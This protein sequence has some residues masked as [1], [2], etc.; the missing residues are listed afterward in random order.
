MGKA[1]LQ[2]ASEQEPVT[3]SNGDDSSEENEA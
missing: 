2:Q 3:E 1:V